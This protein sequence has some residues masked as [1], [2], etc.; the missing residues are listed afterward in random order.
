MSVCDV[1]LQLQ[2]CL[3]QPLSLLLVTAEYTRPAGLKTYRSSPV[4]VARL[5]IETTGVIHVHHHASLDIGSGDSHLGH[6]VCGANTKPS[7]P[8]VSLPSRRLDWPLVDLP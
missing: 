1:G 5:T 8:S 7:V 6:H 2:P 3:K 4:S